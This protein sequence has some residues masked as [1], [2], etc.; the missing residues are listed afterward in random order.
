[1]PLKRSHHVV[2]DAFDPIPYEARGC[3]RWKI[4][5]SFTHNGLPVRLQRRGFLTRSEA[6][7]H[8]ENELYLIR[9]GQRDPHAPKPSR[10]A[11]GPGITT[12]QALELILTWQEETGRLKSSTAYVARCVIR[13]HL[14]PAIGCVPWIGLT[15]TNVDDLVR[16][17]KGMR[18]PR[19]LMVLRSCIKDSRRA[20]LEPPNVQVEPPRVQSQG[21]TDWLSP[22]ELDRISSASSPFLSALWRFLFHSG[23]RIGEA[24]AL[25]WTD[26]DL[27]M[28]RETI[29]VSKSVYRLPGRYVVGSPK[30]GRSRVV[31]LNHQATVALQDVAQVTRPGQGMVAPGLVFPADSG[32]YLDKSTLRKS[33]KAACK[34]AGLRNVTPHVFRHS[35]ASNMVQRGVDLHTVATLLG[36]TSVIMCARYAHLSDNGLRSATRKLDIATRKTKKE[37][38]RLT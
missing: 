22:E 4:D 35:F 11:A 32:T 2:Q 23:L 18:T 24:L 14:I 7:A 13:T 34:K 19:H 15:Q 5:I 20:G 29:S 33:L 25:D 17:A 28:G 3:R 6:M 38:N 9:S 30:N 37:N 16:S 31:P 1:M 36:H 10:Q 12:E 26:L 8:V 27:Q 21:K